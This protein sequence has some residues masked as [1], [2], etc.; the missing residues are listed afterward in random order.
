MQILNKFKSHALTKDQAMYIK[1]GVTRAE[2]CD[3][4]AAIAQSAQA[5]GDAETLALA[6]YYWE[7]H[8]KPYGLP[9]RDSNPL[10]IG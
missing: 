2:Y 3:Q 7:I 6:G 9:A 8:C 1:G 10:E 5:S 4:N